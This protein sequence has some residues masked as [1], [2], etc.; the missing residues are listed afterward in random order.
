M[1]EESL[2]TLFESCVLEVLTPDTSI[3]FPENVVADDWLASVK[4]PHAERKQAF[5]GEVHRILILAPRRSS[6]VSR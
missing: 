3:L 6:R 2:E 1:A 4:Q 5:F